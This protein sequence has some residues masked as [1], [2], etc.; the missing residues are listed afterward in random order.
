MRAIRV[1]CLIA[2]PAVCA[3]DVPADPPLPRSVEEAVARIKSDWLSADD[4]ERLLRSPPGVALQLHL[5]LG[6]R[7]RNQFGLW[8][9]NDALLASCG[10]AHP[11]DCS[12]VILEALWRSIRAD[13]DPKLVRRLDAH[14]EF[15]R[16]IRVRYR[17]FR[18][19]KTGEWLR[20]LRQQVDS[21]IV[22]RKRT[23]G[24]D[25]ALTIRV[26]GDPDPECHTRAEVSEEGSGEA[27]L[28]GFL[29]WFAWRNAFTVR[30]DPPVLELAF[31]KKCAW[32][33]R[34]DGML[35]SPWRPR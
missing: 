30:H 29:D 22:E 28:L 8:R 21:A 20:S 1:A 19:L 6:M 10:R 14:F 35:Y 16:S 18:D 24:D 34:P 3:A 13:A 15:V 32:P 17:G 12:G 4:R 5:G 27:S 7:V 9:G 11:D 23:G 33:Q 2:I 25:V 31:S 26:V